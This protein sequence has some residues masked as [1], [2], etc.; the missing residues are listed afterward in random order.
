VSWILQG[1]VILAVVG[2]VFFVVLPQIADLG[3]VWGVLSSLSVGQ[4][5]VLALL[6]AWNLATY[7][8]MVVAAMPGLTLGQAIVVNQSATSVAMT[9]PAG[10]AVAVGVS[11]AMY[12]SWGFSRSQVA[13][14]ALVTGIW[15]I[16]WKL[17]LPV[18]ALLILVAGG[19]DDIG[20]VSSALVGLVLLAIGATLLIAALWSE[21]LA[22]R[23]GSAVGRVARRVWPRGGRTSALWG[24]SAARFR[25][26]IVDLIRRRWPVLT[27]AELVSQVSVFLV[28][29]A[30]MRFAGATGRDVRWGEA[31]AVFAVVRLASAFPIIPGNVG[32]AELGYVAGLVLAGAGDTQ[33]VAA[34]LLFRLLTYY[35][36]IP[37]GGITYLAWR[38]KQSWRRTPGSRMDLPLE[39]PR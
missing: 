16:S 21:R 25:S 39:A 19:D 20:L 9:V 22:F 35:V 34:V 3:E 33:A 27:A 5:T 36:Q 31:L 13:R 15:N 14:S 29:L 6:A 4:Y 11:Y 12:S 37:I 17:A 1:A 26:Q 18:L 28:L 10:G 7:W 24:A 32:L 8:P 30:S 2:G 38:R 23:V